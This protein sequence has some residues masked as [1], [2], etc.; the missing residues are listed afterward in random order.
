MAIN[1][2]ILYTRKHIETLQENQRYYNRLE[3]RESA[4]KKCVIKQERVLLYL[5]SDDLL[6]PVLPLVSLITTTF[7]I[8]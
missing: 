2:L 6:L 3:V 5:L 1:T 8:D 4:L 7:V